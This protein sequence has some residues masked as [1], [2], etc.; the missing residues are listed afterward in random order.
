MTLS[1]ILVDGLALLTI[2]FWSWVISERLKVRIPIYFGNQKTYQL[3]IV[4]T[5][6]VPNTGRWALLQEL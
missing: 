6:E 5:A 1:S 4:A 3:K 2:R